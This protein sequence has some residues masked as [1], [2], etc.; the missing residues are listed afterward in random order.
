M[1]T[2]GCVLAG[3]F[4]ELADARRAEAREHLD[5]RRRALRV[6]VRAGR[7]RDRLREQRL[8]GAGR[9]VEEDPARDTGAEALEALAVAEE[10]DDLLELGLRLVEPGDVGP[11]DLLRAAHDRCR[12]RT[13]HE[14]ERV[15]QQENDNPEEHDREPREKRVLEIHH[16]RIG[17]PGN[18]R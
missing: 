12:L 13:R 17:S 9:A 14:L 4:E 7:A 8:P 10:L 11:R 5:E 15:E 2:I 6:E 18:A 3:L 1:K 16:S